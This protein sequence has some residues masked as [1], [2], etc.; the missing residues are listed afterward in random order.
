M[1]RGKIRDSS[2]YS[3]KNV[4]I[5]TQFGKEHAQKQAWIY[6]KKYNPFDWVLDET[7]VIDVIE[8]TE[9]EN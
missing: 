4:H 7:E 1:F 2:E 3:E 9:K 5:E 6:L 8:S